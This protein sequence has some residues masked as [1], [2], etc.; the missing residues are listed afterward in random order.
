MK[1]L[2]FILG[3]FT[4]DS[5]RRF[6]PGIVSLRVFTCAALAMFVPQLA[7]SQTRADCLNCHGDK[8]V[9]MERHGKEVSIYVDE[10]KLNRSPHQKLVC[11][12]CHVGFDANNVPHK[13]KIE[14][15]RCQTCHKDVQQ[16]H[17]FH[18]RMI[19]ANGNAGIPDLACKEC[20]GTH[21]IV[22]P[23]IPG[24]KFSHAK[25]AESCGECHA[26]EAATYL[27]SAHGQAYR[28]GVQGAPDCISCHQHPVATTAAVRD[29]AQLKIAQEQVCLSC[30]LDDPAVRAHTSPDAGFIAAYAS[31][32]HGSALARGNGSAANCVDCHGSHSMLKGSDPKS[33][34][35]K[36]N[37]PGT[38]SKCHASIEH[39]YRESVHGVA[40]AK[41]VT[42]APV[43]T[44]CHG[45]H[46]ILKHNDPK[47][48]VAPTN[49]SSQ[50][51]SP[52]H[53]SVRLSSKYGIR[54]DKF[55][56]Y[57]DSYHGLAMRAGDVEVANCASCHGSHSIKPSNDSTSSI[58]KANLAKTCGKCHAGANQ[59]FTEGKVHLTMTAAQE[60]LLYWIATGYVLLILAVVGGMILHNI[61]DF[62]RKSRRR[63]LARRGLLVEEHHG[64]RL[65]LRMSLSE[66][67]QHA[68]LLVSFIALVLTGFA[69]KFPDAWWVAPVRNISPAFF[70]LRG[71]VHRIAAVMMVLASLFHIYYVS[72]NSRGKQLL[73]DLLPNLQDVSDAVGIMKYNLGISPTK[74]KLGRFSYVE[75]S[76]YWALVWGTVVMT[77]TGIILWF[78]N[79][80]LGILSKLWW[81]VAQTVHYYEAWLATLAIIVWH[82]YF[83]IFNPDVY[84]INLAFW[85]G[86]LTE[87]E[88]AEE[89][90]GELEDI[91]RREFPEELKRA[92][93]EEKVTRRPER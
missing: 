59:R 65:Y 16:K 79:T 7:A 14:P 88:M 84:P 70:G 8:S 57:S 53:S 43:C 92:A 62:I 3:S 25:L 2:S 71:V 42:A 63:L 21:D 45:E 48:P 72:F 64:H 60:P 77:L 19:P 27:A 20:H 74:P 36:M 5:P 46:N 93:P 34:V 91:R 17:Q 49:I 40:L 18:P 44:D 47:S 1:I 55:Q 24:S 83:V 12:A 52:C 39:E 73:R 81:D 32:V 33:S 67:L 66:R 30:H 41:G 10:S 82:F 50:V 31:S 51:C 58:N 75:K 85:K 37:I 26:G 13:E 6:N 56:T 54:S 68:T 9:T 15:V 80:F 89:H 86:T 29:T 4:H 76:E 23:R 28:S 61:L 90:P 78:D 11:V 69:L 22:S 35:N 87:E 38:C